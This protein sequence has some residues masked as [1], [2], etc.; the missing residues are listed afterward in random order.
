M[1]LTERTGSRIPYAEQA[2]REL[3]RRILDNELSP[4]ANLLEQEIAAELGMSRTPAREA[5][6][7]LANEGLVEVKP[8]HGMRVLP[9]SADDM[10]EIYLI[11][12]S[13]ESTAA[14]VVAKRGLTTDEFAALETAVSE[15][16]NALTRDDL[17]AWARADE[18]FHQLLL[19]YC[20]NRRLT[21]LVENFW[22]QA[23]RVRMVTL[24]LRPRPI[25]S[26]KDHRQLLEAIAARDSE[27]AREIHSRHR[28]VSGRT[29]VEILRTS[30]LNNV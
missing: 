22:D 29:L 15:M 8:R 19:H 30:G 2:Y 21:A 7:R 17:S 25:N 28:E 20:A 5:M 10:E 11:L 16:D 14:A 6:M 27:K 4:G 3:K 23:H 12:T 24:K 9:I 1:D 18:R 13:L 26:N